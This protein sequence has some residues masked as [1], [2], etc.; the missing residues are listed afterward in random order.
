[1]SQT[2]DLLLAQLLKERGETLPPVPEE[3]KPDLFR[4][5]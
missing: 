3:Q 5:L 2:L 4:A 1:M